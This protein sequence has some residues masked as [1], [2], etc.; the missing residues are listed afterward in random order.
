MDVLVSSSDLGSA[1]FAQA[2]KEMNRRIPTSPSIT[3]GW[4][5]DEISRT[6]PVELDSVTKRRVKFMYESHL[7]K[8]AARILGAA[9]RIQARS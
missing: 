2:T 7:E 6:L 3:I 4:W 8:A 5:I 1:S 9:P